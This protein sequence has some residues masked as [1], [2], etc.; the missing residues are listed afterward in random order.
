MEG[1]I[2]D[3]DNDVLGLID[4]QPTFMPG[5]QLPVPGGDFIVPVINRLLAVFGHAFA[6]QDWHPATHGSFASAH[7]GKAPYATVEMPYGPQTLWPDHAL[8]SSPQ[9]AIHSAIDQSKIEV[10]IRKG[11]RKHVD[12]YSAF[13]ENDQRTATGLDGYLKSRGF[14]RLFL[15]GLATDFCVAYSAKDAAHLGFDVVVVKDACRGI[16]IPI[17]SGLTTIDAAEKDLLAQ[18]VRF[19]SSETILSAMSKLRR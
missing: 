15:A 8:Q 11:F 4:V 1:I 9:A 16:G 17:G 12:S 13:F 19:I 2:I 7:P 3:P 10:I 14:R 6:T 18:G 5:G